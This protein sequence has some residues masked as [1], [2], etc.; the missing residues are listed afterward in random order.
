MY[1]AAITAGFALSKSI[2]DTGAFPWIQEYIPDS[3]RG[4]YYATSNLFCTLSSFSAITIA[5][6]AI[7]AAA[8]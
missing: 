1:V 6:F 3:V 4:K 2:A 7:S 8:C 5:G